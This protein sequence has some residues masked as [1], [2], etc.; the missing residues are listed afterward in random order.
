[1]HATLSHRCNARI[2]RALQNG[3]KRKQNTESRVPGADWHG[4]VVC[5]RASVARVA[6]ALSPATMRWSAALHRDGVGC[7][8]M[9]L[10]RSL[11]PPDLHA[12]AFRM[13]KRSTL[14]G[15]TKRIC[16]PSLELLS[17]RS[18]CVAFVAPF[19]LLAYSRLL[20]RPR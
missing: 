13:T 18:P 2:A 20:A 12:Q 9:C 8:V 4:C 14:D 3:A 5:L 16:S 15:Y 10:H 11:F 7:R 19:V 17:V 6:W 1:M